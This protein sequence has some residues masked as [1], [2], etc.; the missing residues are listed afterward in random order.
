MIIS[1][2]FMVFYSAKYNVWNGRIYINFL[3]RSTTLIFPIRAPILFYGLDAVYM[4]RN[5]F[6]EDRFFF[7]IPTDINV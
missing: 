3:L 6:V 4:A 2:L 7:K 5:V 1:I